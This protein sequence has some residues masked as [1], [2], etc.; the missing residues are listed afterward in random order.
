[1]INAS[2][3]VTQTLPTSPTTTAGNTPTF[4]THN[5]AM[6]HQQFMSGATN[7]TT[8][9]TTAPNPVGAMPPA[10]PKFPDPTKNLI[11]VTPDGSEVVSAS[12]AGST[13]STKPK[14]KMNL[15]LILGVLVLFL[16]LLGSGAGFYLSQQQQELRQKAYV[17][18]ACTTDADCN[19]NRSNPAIA[20]YCV[21]IAPNKTCSQTAP[22]PPT[23]PMCPDNSGPAVWC[24]TFICESDVNGD[25]QCTSAD[26]AQAQIGTGTSCI[27]PN[28]GCGQVDIYRA[29]PS[30]QN[31]GS[32]CGT[33]YHNMDDCEPSGGLNCNDSCTSD[34]QCSSVNSAWTC[35]DASSKCRL[36]SN[37]TS[38][39]CQPATGGTNKT[40][41]GKAYCELEQP[42]S[43][44]Y[45][46]N[47]VPIKIYDSAANNIANATTAGAGTYSSAFGLD[48]GNAF[49]VR[50]GG[51]AGTATNPAFRGAG[52]TLCNPQHENCPFTSMPTTQPNMD[53]KTNVVPTTLAN[54]C[55]ADGHMTITWNKATN[56]DGTKVTNY[57]LRLDYDETQ[58][59]AAAN[60]WKPDTIANGGN[61]HD[62]WRYAPVTVGTCTATTCTVDTHI[63]NQET[64][65]Y[66]KPWK[67]GKYIVN[68]NPVA[69]STLP[70]AGATV[71]ELCKAAQTFT[72][73]TTTTYQCDSACTTN[74]QCATGNPAWSC[75]SNKC[76]LTANPTSATCT[77]VTTYQC[78]SACTTSAQCQGSLGA[79]YS[80]VTNKCRL[81]A[82]PT[83]ATCA[84]ATVT[85]NSVCDPKNMVDVCTAKNSAWSCDQNSSR[86]RLTA[87]PTSVSCDVAVLVCNSP[88]DPK[89]KKDLCTAANDKWSCDPTSS[90]CR[91]TTNP[92][93]TTCAPPVGSV[94]CNEACTSNTQCQNTN[95]N[96]TCD[97]TTN[98]CRLASNP[99]STTCEAVPPKCNE[100]CRTNAECEKGDPDHYCDDTTDTCRLE[101]NPTST[102]CS[103]PA[104]TPTPTPTVG[105]NDTCVT[106]ADCSNSNHICATTED[107]TLKCRLSSYPTSTSC[108]LPATSTAQPTL[109]PALPQTGPEDWMNWLKAGLVT[110]GLGAA[111]FFLL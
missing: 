36:A 29:G 81:T 2:G 33:T 87:N 31:W 9:T 101:T 74:A 24:A 59:G 100:S 40:I 7:T 27:T 38:T 52:A 68:V 20:E 14:K 55:S 26:G 84:A 18:V 99:T 46:I 108:T 73:T 3:G 97:T 28:N 56:Y 86:C 90:A 70:G 44:L 13:D 50:V 109:P 45:T 51:G 88:C 49:A 85:C 79:A 42:T 30:G 15:K 23:G 21:G 61:P 54:T 34:S 75:V 22:P 41:S 8:S 64:G 111:L 104:A 102:T 98:T 62:Y 69:N 103:E 78:D 4:P 80:C 37:P 25:G 48:L 1:M 32:F 39:S 53:F 19:A 89:A 6:H 43:P 72:C 77:P 76:R 47:N 106:N 71:I 11:K 58:D 93:S 83:S 96:Y 94:A 35:D 92:T 107:G 5:P 60:T 110:L 67:T 10:P 105:C 66:A 95:A 57:I 82:N 65:A 63:F 17:G 91:F 16:V 12:G